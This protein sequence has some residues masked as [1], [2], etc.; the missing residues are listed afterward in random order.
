MK[1]VMPAFAVIPLH[2]PFL[3]FIGRGALLFQTI[4]PGNISEFYRTDDLAFF[5]HASSFLLV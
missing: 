3:A 1:N 4:L 2:G 5:C